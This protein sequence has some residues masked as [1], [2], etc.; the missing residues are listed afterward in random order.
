[1]ENLT[2]NEITKAIN[3]TLING[4]G[5]GS[6]SGISTDSRSIGGGDMFFAIIG[7]KYDGHQYVDMAVD[8]GCQAL[9]VSSRD[10]LSDLITDREDISCILVDDTL[11][12]YQDLAAYYKDLI[13]PVTIAVTGSVGKTSLKDML[14]IISM[15]NFN[16][17]CTQGNENN[18][19]GVPRT[20]FRMKK[21][22]EVLI[23]EMG[24]NHEGEIRRLAQIGRPSITAITNV[25]ISHLENFH[26]P[27]DILDAKMEIAE[28]LDESGTLVLYG[29]DPLLKDKINSGVYNTISVGTSDYNDYIISDAKYLD[30][31]HI[32]FLIEYDNGVERFTLPVAGLYNSI[33]VAMAVA[34]MSKLNIS[35][36]SC[37]RSLQKLE[38]T[39]SRLQLI[40]RNGLKIIDD[41]YNASPDSMK[42]GIDYLVAIEADR[43][44]AILA[45]MKELGPERKRLHAEVGEY[46]AASGIDYL[47]TVGELAEYIGEGAA[48]SMGEDRVFSFTN[49]ETCIDEVKKIIKSGDGVLVKGSNSMKM[50]EV[51]EALDRKMLL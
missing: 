33:T 11:R 25:G 30:D 5:N 21:N 35:V 29:D 18:H 45:D 27:S 1:M 43:K 8:K 7:D 40:E 38:M 39:P 49:R 41:T 36:V 37:A 2:I 46:V 22:T 28:N 12:A 9:V 3:G 32:T 10:S 13:S 16:T 47:F 31:N 4:H 23:L 17:V 6:V 48:K 19:M 34:I 24:M 51:V 50:V 14:N 42:S 26:S 15:D 44:I 20:I